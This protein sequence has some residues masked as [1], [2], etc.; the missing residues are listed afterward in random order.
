MA[1][2]DLAALTPRQYAGL[3]IRIVLGLL[4]LCHAALMA[5]IFGF[6]HAE[7]FFASLALPASMA[8]AVAASELVGAAMLLLGAHV[9]AVSIALGPIAL[10]TALVHLATGIGL[11]LGYAAYLAGCLVLQGLLAGGALTAAD[12]GVDSPIVGDMTLGA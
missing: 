10:L 1:T 4:Y 8:Y 2:N 12:D 7:H 5:L 3:M 6:E 9:R 11:C